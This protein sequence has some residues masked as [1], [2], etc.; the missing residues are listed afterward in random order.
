MKSGD[1]VKN[2]QEQTDRPAFVLC[3]QP[4][5]ENQ[6]RRAETTGEL[7]LCCNEPAPAAAWLFRALYSHSE[8]PEA[9][10]TSTTAMTKVM[11]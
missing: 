8:D 9:V 4:Q 1:S 5:A 6:L 7:T 10:Q 11:L 3:Q 2:Y